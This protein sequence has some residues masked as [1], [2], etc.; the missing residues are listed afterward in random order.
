MRPEPTLNDTPAGMTGAEWRGLMA[1]GEALLAKGCE[2][3]RAGDVEQAVEILMQAL[4]LLAGHLAR[5]SR[6]LR[7]SRRVR[8]RLGRVGAW[9]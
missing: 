7:R 5:C 2:L 6:R 9:Q 1:E 3:E 4:G 8:G